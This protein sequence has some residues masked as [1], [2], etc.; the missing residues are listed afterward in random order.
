MVKIYPS[1]IAADILNLQREIKLLEPYCQGYHVDIMD[2]H[3][4]PN[5]TWGQM[6]VDAIDRITAKPLWVQLMVDD[7]QNWVDFLAL[8]A[9]SIV[10]FHFESTSSVKNISDRIKKKN[11]VPSIAINPKTPVEKIFPFLDIIPHVVI[12]SVEPGFSGQ[13]FLPKVID[14]V[15]T[16]VSYCQMRGLKITVGMDGGIKED[17]ISMLAKKGVED[18][19][20]GS[21]IFN[22]ENRISAIKKLYEL[23]NE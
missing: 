21:G 8:N 12:M 16:L 17:N 3:F 6:F 2:N 10:T 23:A 1:L 20:I 18:F 4:V 22:H 13:D 15:D 9:N 14:K 11:W 19:V 5:L 7:P